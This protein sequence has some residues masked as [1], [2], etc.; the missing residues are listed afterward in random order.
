L[1]SDP[2]RRSARDSRT[3]Q[4]REIVIDSGYPDVLHHI[5]LRENSAAAGDFATF[6]RNVRYCFY[7]GP[8][9]TLWAGGDVPNSEFDL[10]VPPFSIPKA[11]YNGVTSSESSAPAG[12]PFP[13][14]PSE[15]VDT[16]HYWNGSNW[17]NIRSNDT[18]EAFRW[19]PI[20][21]DPSWDL[22]FDGDW[23]DDEDY[24]GDWLHYATSIIGDYNLVFSADIQSATVA[25]IEL[26]IMDTA[27]GDGTKSYLFLDD[28]A[29]VDPNTSDYYLLTQA[30]DAEN[31]FKLY[32]VYNQ[33]GE[34]T[35]DGEV[36]HDGDIWSPGANTYA[37]V[38]MQTIPGATS[39]TQ[40]EEPTSWVTL[41]GDSFTDFASF[42][43]VTDIDLSRLTYLDPLTLGGPV[44]TFVDMTAFSRAHRPQGSGPIVPQALRSLYQ[45]AL[46]AQQPASLAF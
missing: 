39:R 11:G 6:Y 15:G 28:L 22:N 35:L 41:G 38:V 45:T 7:E 33:D 34:I 42:L 26:K 13:W 46:P 12:T 4:E 20:P 43:S 40:M 37:T 32:Y 14:T 44:N 23:T 9:I 2:V 29:I 30:T 16:T 19:M 18:T 27:F 24:F 3:W 5:V 17:D 21:I 25:S 1:F 31:T 36:R 8:E 10:S